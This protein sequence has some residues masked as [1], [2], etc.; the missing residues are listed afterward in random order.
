VIVLFMVY[1]MFYQNHSDGGI[2]KMKKIFLLILLTVLLSLSVN[3]QQN[4]LIK[5]TDIN[6]SQVKIQ[7]LENAVYRVRSEEQKSY[8]ELVMNKV[9][10]KQQL[11]LNKLETLTIDT[12][13]FDVVE[14]TGYQEDKLFGVIKLKHQHKYQIDDEGNVYRVRS[15]FNWMWV[16]QND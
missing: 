4:G 15:V 16:E 7:G 3:A 6:Y 1:F 14:A 12:N 5:K 8:M 10:E 11:R 13:D 2:D 9:Q